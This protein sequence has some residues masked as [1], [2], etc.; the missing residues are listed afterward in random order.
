MYNFRITCTI[1][2]IFKTKKCTSIDIPDIQYS[3]RTLEVLVYSYG[4]IYQNYYFGLLLVQWMVLFHS[5][6]SHK[7]HIESE[8]EHTREI[9]MTTFRKAPLLC[10]TSIAIFLIA[11]ITCSC[12]A[13]ETTPYD[14][15]QVSFGIYFD[16]TI[17]ISTFSWF[18]FHCTQNH[19]SIS[20]Q[21]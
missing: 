1:R 9:I 12:D 10:F 4:Y 17:D 8:L 6:S 14:V 13:Q 11:S 19:L 7:I 3:T 5:I 15:Y 20:I 18:I 2:V 21:S 16:S